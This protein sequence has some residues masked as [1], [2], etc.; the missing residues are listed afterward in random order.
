MGL[1]K[2]CS[3]VGA[4]LAPALSEPRDLMINFETNNETKPFPLN[5]THFQVDFLDE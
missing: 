5:Q 4:G 3:F 2:K 1:M